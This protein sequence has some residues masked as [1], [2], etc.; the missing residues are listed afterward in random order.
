MDTHPIDRMR[1]KTS[2]DCRNRP[3]PLHYPRAQREHTVFFNA[4]LQPPE[5]ASATE[6]AKS[7][8]CLRFLPPPTPHPHSE[9][10]VFRPHRRHRYMPST[11][12]NKIQLDKYTCPLKLHSRLEAHV[13][14]LFSMRCSPQG[15]ESLSL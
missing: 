1:P 4:L 5:D 7:I 10:E 9:R 8:F 2:W 14:S 15:F 6:A 12:L 13:S 3:A 11:S